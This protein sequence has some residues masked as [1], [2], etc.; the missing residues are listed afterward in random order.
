LNPDV[1]VRFTREVL[2]AALRSEVVGPAEDP[3]I[4]LS[5]ALE[6]LLGFLE[7]QRAAIEFAPVDAQVVIRP[8]DTPA[9]I[10]G[11]S[12][13]L[14]DEDAL[15]GAVQAAASVR[16]RSGPFPYKEGAE[17]DLT[18]A[19]AEDLGIKELISYHDGDVCCTTFYTPGGDE[20][21]QNRVHNIQ[22][23]ADTVNGAIVMP[24][25]TFSLNDYVGQR[26]VEK[27]YRPAGAIIGPIIEC[28][29][30]P[31][32]IGGGVSQFTTTLYNA[33]F[34]SG[35]ED[36]KHTPHTLYI[37]RYPEGLEATLG[38]PEPD[39]VFRN[40]TAAAVYIKT[41]H[42]ADSI[43]V[44][45]FGDNGGIRVSMERSERSYPTQPQDYF[46]PDPTVTPGEERVDT[47]G[48]PGFTVTVF[49]TITYPNG[50]ETT[51]QWTWRYDPWPNRV[52][53]HPC[54]LPPYPACP[55]GV[56][57]LYGLGPVQAGNRL[58]AVD[59]ILV[60]AGTEPT[61]NP[62]LDGKV[63]RQSPAAGALLD[64]DGQVQVWFGVYTE[65]G[66]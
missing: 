31:A 55:S 25:E 9:V 41:E 8:D 66:G 4:Q 48:T 44:K 52:S 6:P 47:E 26:T 63:V 24:G 19:E 53:V 51:E 2:A 33:V 1:Q 21:N 29:D 5:F 30:D 61:S 23:M 50:T 11:R 36:V 65:G 35:L 38:W 54:D 32:N 27:G 34:W 18:T 58:Q 14:I 37:S 46:E 28:C 39:L 20:K 43:T 3:Q 22:L 57:D 60:N 40:N 16:S 15:A 64:P 12:A 45:F 42:T 7:P 49:R 59:L 13:L 17:P 62:D 56:P 10:P